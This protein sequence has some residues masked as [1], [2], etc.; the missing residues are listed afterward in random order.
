MY[1][2]KRVWEKM[3]ESTVK[4]DVP[5]WEKAALSLEEASEYTGVGICK[6]RELSNQDSCNFVIWI[7]R[8]RLLKRKKLEEY[9]E[10]A[11]SI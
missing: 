7:G 10:S 9:L 3:V 6:L 5:I 4:Q 11:F 8:K 1:P 2:V